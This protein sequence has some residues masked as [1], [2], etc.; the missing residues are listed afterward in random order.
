METEVE[1][2]KNKLIREEVDPEDCTN[3]DDGS[4]DLKKEDVDPDSF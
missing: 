1:K 2:S 3:P 4:G